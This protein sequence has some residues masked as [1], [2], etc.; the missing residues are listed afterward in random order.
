MDLSAIQA[1]GDLDSGDQPSLAAQA[2]LRSAG[3]GVVV[4]DR[5]AAHAGA[6]HRGEQIARR[7]HAVA[8]VGME[9]EVAAHGAEG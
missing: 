3:Q 5:E 7:E 8:V 6:P 9:V 4:G 2:P 1:G